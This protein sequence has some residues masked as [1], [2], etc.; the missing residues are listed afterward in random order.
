MTNPSILIEGV[1]ADEIISLPVDELRILIVT[2][3]PVVFHVGSATV[4]GEFAIHEGTLQIELAHIDGGGEGVL[5]TIAA[6]AQRLAERHELTVIEWLVY[7]TNCARP[8]PKLARVLKS[9]GFVVTTRPGKGEC[10][11]FRSTGFVYSRGD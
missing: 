10:Y 4:L 6:I 11:F 9:R 2:G 7:A 3:K 8:N 5:S 1:T